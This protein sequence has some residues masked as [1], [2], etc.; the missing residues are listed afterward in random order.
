MFLKHLYY[1]KERFTKKKT[2]RNKNDCFFASFRLRSIFENELSNIL[3][4]LFLN[5]SRFKYLNLKYELVIV[6]RNILKEFSTGAY[7]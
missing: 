1:L 2:H 3:F 6:K 7:R 4:Q 5:D